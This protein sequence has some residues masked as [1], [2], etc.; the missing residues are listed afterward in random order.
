MPGSNTMISVEKRILLHLLN[1]SRIKREFNVPITLT[2]NGVAEAVG[3]NR[4]Y[5]PRPLKK[6]KA[7]GYIKEYLGRVKDGKKKQKYYLVTDMGKKYAKKFKEKLSNQEI[8]LK[9]QNGL[10]ET[11]RIE[12]VRT[13]LKSL[14]I[15]LTITEL[16]L[17]KAISKESILDIEQFKR[18]KKIRYIDF[19]KEAPKIIHFFGRKE[20][21]RKLNSWLSKKEE[22]NLIFIH[23]IAGIGKTTLAAKLID[24]YRESKHLFWH[25]FHNMDT[26]RGVLHKLSEFL[27][28]L[29]SDHLQMYLK[30]RTSIDHYEVSRILKRSIG[31]IDAILVFDDFHK[32]DEKIRTFF[33]YILKMLVS[34]SNTKI[35]LLG[36]E[37]VPFYDSRD[38]LMRK[39]VAELEL[40]GLDYE[41]SKVLLKEKG[42]DKKKVKEI[43]TLTAGN[44]LFLEIVESKGHLERYIHD[45]LFSKLEENE[46]NIL[47]IIS[48][49]R[50]PI[51]E[52]ML[53]SNFDVDIE[54]LYTITQKS[55]VKKDANDRYFIHDIMKHFFYTRL[56]STTRRGYHLKAARWYE[57]RGKPSY[58]IEAIYHY[59][60]SGKHKKASQLAVKRSSQILDEGYAS[61]LLITLDRFDEREVKNGIWTRILILKGKASY[62]LGEWKQALLYLAQSEDIASI[63]GDNELKVNAICESG[64]ILEEQNELGKAME[65]FSRCLEISKRT[66]FLRGMAV[67]YR[68]IGRV[69]WRKSE[70]GKAIKNYRKCLDI[71][72]R[73]NDL[74]LEASTYIDLGN[75]Y[76]ER[77]ETEKAIECYNKSLDLL[78]NVKNIYETARAYTNLAVTCRH[79]GEF[80]EAIEYY[81]E[82]LALAKDIRDIKR[83]GYDYAGMSSCFVK[84]EKIESAK[85][86]AKKA[87]DIALKID[88]ENIMFDV[89]RTYA[90]I[91]K[92]E[93]KWDKAIKYFQKSIEIVEKLNAVFYLSHSHL[94][95]GL[96]YKKMGDADNAEKHIKIAEK[97]YDNLDLR[98]SSIIR[99]KHSNVGEISQ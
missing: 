28:E 40:E 60:E 74:E 27:L 98:G 90:L 65:S 52:E 79:L 63:I 50:F 94:E 37:I 16:D 80:D 41:S 30:T 73:N 18:Q 31:V 95:F 56:S 10:K 68:G 15:N 53:T 49:Y 70:H 67:A 83:M 9:H 84:I 61:E 4:N 36:R 45:E 33:V 6:L 14:D 13:Q 89:N 23:G 64:L 8:I 2:R 97:L 42:F 47:G 77:Y 87:E 86:Y 72:E 11:I 66:D 54:K 5:I 21:L 48:I 75:V 43:Y 1:Y 82:S 51:A 78:R 62:M 69:H 76:D 25:N 96:L 92:H 35:L 39:I 59:Q 7:K 46:R 91:Y 12:D 34:P 24:G 44:P 32:C 22:N 58:L 20:E 93:K 17:Y 88:N 26:L 29:G 99:E 85:N 57:N 71:S 3:T 81:N 55:I 19:S 38:V